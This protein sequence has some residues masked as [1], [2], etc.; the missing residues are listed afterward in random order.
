MSRSKEVRIVRDF[1]YEAP[2]RADVSRTRKS[3]VTTEVWS[4]H[5]HKESYHQVRLHQRGCGSHDL[6]LTSSFQGTKYVR[7]RN[8]NGQ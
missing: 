5:D 6:E 7:N 1:G 4:T 8:P 2:F 3:A